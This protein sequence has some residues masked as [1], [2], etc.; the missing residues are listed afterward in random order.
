M[1]K[2]CKGD[3]QVVVGRSMNIKCKVDDQTM[4]DNCQISKM[5]LGSVES[6]NG[7]FLE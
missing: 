6:I 2:C 3:D 5:K 1:G 4:I 7:S